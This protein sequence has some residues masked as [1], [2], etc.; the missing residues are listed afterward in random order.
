MQQSIENRAVAVYCASSTGKQKAF[1]QAAISVGHALGKAGRP[2]VYGGGRKGIMGVVSGAVLEADGQVTG[3]LPA[4]M[5]A[6]GGEKEAVRSAAQAKAAA[7]A[8]CDGLN[9]ENIVVDSMHERKFEMAKRSCGFIC[10]PG[11]YGTFEELLEV[12]T[13]SQLGIHS[14]P[15]I[16]VNVLGYYDPLRQLI[17]NG[18][19]EGFI[20]ARNEK[21]V[22][23]VDGPESYADHE[24]FDWGKAALD[25]LDG[26]QAGNYEVYYDW[27]KRKGADDKSKDGEMNAA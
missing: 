15:A 25:T 4:A 9:R 26:W 11:G 8:L 14:K 6:S 2:L 17:R 20:A 7:A 27:T 19:R 1:E 12:T 21:L 16:V 10:L 3:V 23:F 13:W 5:I 18:V 24:A 22:L